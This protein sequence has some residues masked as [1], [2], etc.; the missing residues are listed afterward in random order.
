MLLKLIMMRDLE[1][2]VDE[3]AKVVDGEVVVGVVGVGAFD[4]FAPVA[5]LVDV[6]LLVP[7]VAWFVALRSS[8]LSHLAWLLLSLP[9]NIF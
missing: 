7:K 5:L 2:L 1:E 4:E 9:K 8:Q 3:G 6:V